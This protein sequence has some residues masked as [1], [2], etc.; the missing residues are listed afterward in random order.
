MSPKKIRK[1]SLRKL[2]L[3]AVADKIHTCTCTLKVREMKIFYVVGFRHENVINN[4]DCYWSSKSN[5]SFSCNIYLG[6]IPGSLQSKTYMYMNLIFS[7]LCFFAMI[8]IGLYFSQTVYEYVITTHTDIPHRHTGTDT[9]T[10]H[11]DRHTDTETHRRRQ[12]QTDTD[13]QTQ[14]DR[15]TTHR[16]TGTPHTDIELH[17]Q[18]DTHTHHTETHR[19]RQTHT[20][21]QTDR[22]TTH[23]HT[24]TLTIL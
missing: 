8:Q 10:H 4:D 15:H 17:R 7:Y 20:E 23:T 12:T 9:Y 19:R 14:T 24:Q 1:I 18:T 3:I 2:K 21:T 16:Q 11:T 5:H 6:I 13:R 22:H